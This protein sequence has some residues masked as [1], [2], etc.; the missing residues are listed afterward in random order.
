MATGRYSRP[1]AKL[2]QCAAN[3]ARSSLAT[4]TFLGETHDIIDPDAAVTAR[5]TTEPVNSNRRNHARPVSLLWELDLPSHGCAQTG[6]PQ[7]R[8]PGTP[9]RQSLWLTRT[10]SS[11]RATNRSR[12][13]DVFDLL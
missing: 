2:S 5:Q 7:A 6:G 4:I 9:R 12:T 3:G 11:S 8:E 13:G 1:I 10:S